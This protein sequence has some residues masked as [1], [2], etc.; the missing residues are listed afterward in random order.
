MARLGMLKHLRPTARETVE[1]TNR[2]VLAV[3]PG[4]QPGRPCLPFA[5]RHTGAL[6]SQFSGRRIVRDGA[7]QNC[8]E[9]K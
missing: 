5:Y 9:H 2:I 8:A 3:D 1:T 7:R 4:S 6:L